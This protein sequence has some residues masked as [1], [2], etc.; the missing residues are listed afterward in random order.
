[1]D[2]LIF[3][4]LIL[5]LGLLSLPVISLLMLRSLRKRVNKLEKLVHT[6]QQQNAKPP[7]PAPVVAQ[8]S[9]KP[10]PVSV[11]EPVTVKPPSSALIQETD[12]IPQSDIFKS[13]V[14]TTEEIKTTNHSPPPPLPTSPPL[15]EEEALVAELKAMY[16]NDKPTTTSSLGLFERI[17]R[18]FIGGNIPVNIGIVVLLAG[19]AALIKYATEQGLLR[20]PIELRLIAISL[21]ALGALKFAW[22][23]RPTHPVFSLAVQGGAIGVLLLVVFAAHKLYRFLPGSVAFALSAGLITGLAVLAVLQYSRTLA[24]LGILAGFLAPIWLSD[25]SGSHIGLFAWY[26]LVNMGIFVMAWLRPWRALNL[27]GFVFTWGIGI[28]WGVL[29]YNPEKFVSSQ[30]FLLLF[31]SF[32][33]LLPLFYARRAQV[34]SDSGQARIDG[35]LVFGTP[36]V[37]FSLQSG[38]LAQRW[39]LALCALALALVYLA[40][41]YRL[42]QRARRWQHLTQAY[43]ILAVGFATL[44]V[45]LALSA[46]ATACV[47]ALEGAGLVWLGL[48]QRNHLAHWSGIGLQWAAAFSWML[49]LD[50]VSIQDFSVITNA[51]CISGVLIALA[52]FVIAGLYSQHSD[53]RPL[54][55][56]PYLWGLAWWMMIWV[57]E[58]LIYEDFYYHQYHTLWR[59]T[60]HTILLLF[61]LT[62]WWAAFVRRYVI[63]RTIGKE[64]YAQ[65]M[66]LLS[67][68]VLFCL[69]LAFA[70]AVAQ[71]FA[72]PP[73]FPGR[74]SAW[75]GGT[76]MWLLFALLT[77]HSV[78]LLRH[79]E[80]TLPAYSQLVWLL[81]WPSVWMLEVLGRPWAAGWYGL[82]LA[83]PWLVLVTLSIYRWEWLCWPLGAAFDPL[84]K[85]VQTIGLGI[86]SVWW[87]MWLFNAGNSAP[88][89]W[90]VVLNPLDL[91]H[92]AILLLLV[93][94]LHQH[95]VRLPVPVALAALVL[96]TTMTL[97]AVHHWGHLPWNRYLWSSA[98]T[99][100]S[101]TVVWSLL[102]MAG[103]IIGSKRG[104]W[105]LWL[106]GALLMGVVL[107]K[108]FLIDRSNLGNLPGIAA[109]IIY[110]LFC[111]AV[112]GLAPAPPR[113]PEYGRK[114]A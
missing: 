88:L 95:N 40:L 14:A 27:L 17:E 25:G 45:P 56:L 98:V 4:S 76:W 19:V 50:S 57:R 89:S 13:K 62:A 65:G 8:A 52:G 69:L 70:V 75:G 99:Q 34:I 55:L 3:L 77:M 78:Y 41:A 106:S 16:E 110:G 83:L 5:L 73:I 15:S 101:L 63:T 29:Q 114:Q 105:G 22:N 47:F 1:V 104:S 66:P 108:L 11:A 90:M 6:L 84:R 102:G 10:K 91:A 28:I 53:M 20:L 81:L 67:G 74:V 58:I 68:T 100:T 43:A 39:P 85:T 111:T 32:Y 87:L 2:F 113:K 48:T 37:A 86:L 72:Y 21:A 44:A 112:G 26:G 46:N 92:I 61:G 82:M 79:A 9:V 59:F 49:G 109:F 103:W 24:I 71:Y 93:L 51:M 12:V 23:K 35:T 97:R 38:L 64:M 7:Q 60:L 31:F 42:N 96:I 94:C 107:C 30:L 80:G 54:A 18:W 33:L 36:L